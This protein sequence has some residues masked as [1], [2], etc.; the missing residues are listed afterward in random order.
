M[1]STLED[2][3]HL[4]GVSR[5]TVSRVINEDPRVSP[6]TRERV[7]EVVRR[8]QYRPNLA[9]RG[10]A[11]GQTNVVGAVMPGGFASLMTDPFFPSLLQGMA[12]AA[13]AHDYFV[14]LSLG[15]AGFRHTIDEV[16][17]QGVVAGVIFSPGQLGDPLLE[18]LIRAGVPIVGVGRCEDERVSYVDVDNMGSARQATSHLL[19]LG[20]RRVATITGPSF[21]PAAHDRLQ[22]YVAAIEASGRSVDET[23]IYEGDFS[24][25]SGRAGMRVMLEHRPD[26]VFAA[27]DRMAIGALNEIRACG[28]RVPD[29]IALV[30]FDDAPLA[31]ELEPPLTTIR[32]RPAGLGRAAISLLLDLIANPN[33][34]P[35]RVIL[36]TELV[37]RGSCGSLARA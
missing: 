35:R 25:A 28:L 33:S 22:G 17:K 18:P 31:A 29:D 11:S 24:E 9:A 16:A 21:A 14:M 36:P 13:D 20:Y 10:L 37:V 8:E 1:P 19:R 4:C 32:Q 30:G 34:P 3:A 23:L 2:I 5:S 15:E 27:S 26:A 6:A 7:L 12:M